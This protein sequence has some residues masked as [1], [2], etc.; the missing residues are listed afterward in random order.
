[1]PPHCDSMDGPVVKAAMKALDTHD[2]RAVLPFV[3]E[4][5][6]AEVTEAFE[7][8][9]KLRMQ[10]PEAREIADRHFFETVVRIHRAGE[11]APFTGLKPAGLG[12]GPVVPVAEKA[13]ENG[14]AEALVKLLTDTVEE[15]IRERFKHVM[16]LKA[17]ASGKGVEE[18][19]EYVEAMLGLEVYSHKLYECAHA[20][21]HGEDAHHEHDA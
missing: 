10:S 11:G 8:V 16:R 3:P 21:P 6:E 4:A 13:I 17:E 14:S 5:G 1:M 18:A 7:K 12:H 9:M 15:Q 20:K 19:R 2:V